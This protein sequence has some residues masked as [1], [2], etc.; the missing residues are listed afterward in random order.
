VS[1]SSVSAQLAS[2]YVLAS[3]GKDG[4]FP[5]VIAA[6]GSVQCAFNATLIDPQVLQG[7]VSATAVSTFGTSTSAASAPYTLQPPKATDDT[8]NCVVVSD[9]VTPRPVLPQGGLVLTG[10]R[11]YAPG[12]TPVCTDLTYN[13]TASFGPFDGTACNLYTV[14][15]D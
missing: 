13:V 3:C 11:P 9:S 1:A 7:S 4:R 15:A 5:V 14:R 12:A 8:D 6:G 2:G 10:S